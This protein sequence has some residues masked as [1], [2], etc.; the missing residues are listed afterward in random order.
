ML[1]IFDWDGT[2][3]DSTGKIIRCMQQAVA[4]LGLEQRSDQQVRDIIG[5]GLPEAIRT[6]FPAI[7]EV[8]LIALRDCYSQH[9][10]AADKMPCEFFPQV[11]TVLDCLRSDGHRL[12]VA[13]GKSRRGLNRILANVQMDD[14]FDATRCADETQSKPHP[15]MLQQLLAQLQVERSQA[16]MVGDTDFDL[17]M[18]ANAGIESIAVSYGAHSKERLIAQRPQCFIDSFEELLLWSRQ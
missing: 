11:L 2:L 12:A 9:F 6:L 10:I 18:A 14:Y 16:V 17:Q 4:D 7:D 8:T 5:L 1:F 3:I 15:L 13:T